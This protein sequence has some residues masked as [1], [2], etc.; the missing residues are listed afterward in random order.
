[1][2]QHNLK[3]AIRRVDLNLSK[4][5]GVKKFVLDMNLIIETPSGE[6]LNITPDNIL[7]LNDTIDLLITKRK[8]LAKQEKEVRNKLDKMME[9]K[10]LRNENKL[11]YDGLSEIDKIDQYIRAIPLDEELLEKKIEDT[12]KQIKNIKKEFL[13]RQNRIIGLQIKY[14][15][16]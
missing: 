1:M 6:V 9:E 8:I 16:I 7:G 5:K 10:Y 2:L 4:N 11:F 15:I 3:K 12:K 14:L 13:I